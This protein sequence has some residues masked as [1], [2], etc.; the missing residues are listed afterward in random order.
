MPCFWSLQCLIR[1]G[2]MGSVENH[3]KALSYFQEN[4][5]STQTPVNVLRKAVSSPRSVLNYKP[6]ICFSPSHL[7]HRFYQSNIS[8]TQFG[9]YCSLLRTNSFPHCLQN[10]KKSKLL[11][12]GSKLFFFFLATCIW[13]T[14]SCQCMVC[15]MVD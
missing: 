1:S 13:R 15:N 3:V 10:R 4:C 12:L 9:S 2:V 14:T 5:K 8:N 11:G 7:P 6:L